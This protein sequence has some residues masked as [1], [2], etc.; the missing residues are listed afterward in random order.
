LNE[1]DLCNI[2][3]SQLYYVIDTFLSCV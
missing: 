1:E 3:F 2:L